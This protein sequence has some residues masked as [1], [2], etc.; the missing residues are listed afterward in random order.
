MFLPSL[1]LE[2]GPEVLEYSPVSRR[3]S[4]RQSAWSPRGRSSVLYMLALR[5]SLLIP[6]F[7]DRAAYIPGSVDSIRK[8]SQSA[9]CSLCT[10]TL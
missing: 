8:L 2:M 1:P 4:P 3:P 5:G 6:Q 10:N 9:P 7:E